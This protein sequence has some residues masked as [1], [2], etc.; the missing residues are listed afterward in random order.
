[1][2]VLFEQVFIL[3]IFS[4]MGYFL[5]KR[6]LVSFENSKILSS[7]LVYVFLP[8]NT[9]RT[10]ANN[11]TVE[12][13][14][15][16]YNMILTSLAV[17]L[18]IMAL[19]PFLVNRL[20][21]DSYE[22]H[23]YKYSLVVPN[24][25]YMGYPLAENLLGSAGL[26]NIMIFALP[27]TVYIYT[28]G[29]AVLTKRGVELKKILS[30]TMVA[31]IL[32][33]IVGLLQIPIPGVVAT[34]LKNASSCMGPVGMLLTGIVISEFKLKEILGDVNIYIITIIR[35]IVVPAVVGA[36]LRMFG[37]DELTQIAVL[38]LALPC[39][40][41]TIIFPK[42]V[43]ENCKI[44]AGLALTSSVLACLTIPVLLT[45]FAI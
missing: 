20:T 8:F 17:V 22:K 42:M 1:M 41:N 34:I 7:L 4:A 35:L 10:F 6:S 31:V 15:Q 30:P 16:K 29:F 26:M 32:G 3:F 43:E 2:L 11:F 25:A 37:V 12:Y 24:Y 13:I 38:F 36:I 14:S 18:I 21:K 45:I 19:S 44:G 27:V 5:C 28:I 33:M 23:I 9:F 40:L 39:G